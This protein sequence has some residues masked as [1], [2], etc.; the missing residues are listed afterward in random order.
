M[1]AKDF[2]HDAVK[3]AL[4]KDGWTITS[5][6]FTMRYEDATVFADL[7]AEHPIGAEKSGTKI[8][9]EVKSFTGPSPM[10]DLKLALGQYQMYYPLLA[11][12][13]PD[14]K[15]YLAVSDTAYSQ[16]FRRKSVQV[17]IEWN[18]PPLLV[19]DVLT[20]EIVQWIN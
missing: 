3:N 5:D 13:A 18:H 8:V 11:K 12:V 4:I 1:S 2:I 7:A 17:I 20:E 19:V 10:Q 15:L 9:V 16:V 6:P 14:H